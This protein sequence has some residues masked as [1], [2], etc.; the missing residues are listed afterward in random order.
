[1]TA[2]E[3]FERYVE[4]GYRFVYPLPNS[5]WIWKGGRDKNG[6]GLFQVESRRTV[7]AHRHSYEQATGD[8][9]GKRLAL[10][11]C[12]TPACVNPSHIR[13]GT[14]SE[15]DGDKVKRGRDAYRKGSRHYGAKLTEEQVTEIRS[16]ATTGRTYQSLADQFSVSKSHI[17]NLVTRKRF[18]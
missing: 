2:S 9:L 1:M 12:D 6:Y 7:R 13:A 4:K 16:L 3:R 18:R 5:C 8:L 14:A 17:G 11:E 10:H 15:N